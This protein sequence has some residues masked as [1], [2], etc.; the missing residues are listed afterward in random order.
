MTRPQPRHRHCRLRLE[1]C[2]CLRCLKINRRRRMQRRVRAPAGRGGELGPR[3][4]Q[5]RGINLVSWAR[6]SQPLSLART[7]FIVR[8]EL[9]ARRRRCRRRVADGR[10]LRS[11]ASSSSPATTPTP[12]AA[13]TT[14][15]TTITTAPEAD[16]QRERE[17]LASSRPPV[18]ACRERARARASLLMATCRRS[19]RES[20]AFGTRIARCGHCARLLRPLV[21]AEAG[22]ILRLARPLRPVDAI[23]ARKRCGPNTASGFG[24]LQ[25]IGSQRGSFGAE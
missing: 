17:R 12:A 2:R 3:F 20:S 22:P 10:A 15:T 19:S 5:R 9:F 4:G 13:T 11:Q 25:R 6:R 21:S 24:P 8:C 1:R 23:A 14:T 18:C 7:E 16:Q